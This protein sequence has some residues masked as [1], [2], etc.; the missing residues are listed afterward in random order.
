MHTVK[1]KYVAMYVRTSY[2]NFDILQWK[3]NTEWVLKHDTDQ[4]T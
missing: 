4:L 1:L 3:Y 2:A